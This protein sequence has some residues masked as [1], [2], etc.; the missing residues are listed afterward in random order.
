[1]TRE[2]GTSNSTPPRADIKAGRRWL[3]LSR[4]KEL[5]ILVISILAV[6]YFTA[7]APNFTN[8]G[9]I[10]TLITYVAPTAIIAVG[11]APLMI[12]GEIDVSVGK[13]FAFAPIIVVLAH[14]QGLPLPLCVIVALA[15]SGLIG[16]MNGILTVTT[17][18]SS[19]IITLAMYFLVNG[20]NLILTDG[21]PANTPGSGLYRTVMGA[22][23]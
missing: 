18:I 1:M 5:P 8:A 16:A 10:G 23:R 6:I 12:S 22:G 21:I 19:F 13:V 3:A 17:G 4:H 20:L 14:Q 2:T 9:S 7:T 15:A 11:L